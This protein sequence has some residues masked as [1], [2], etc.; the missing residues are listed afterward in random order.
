MAD[1]KDFYDKLG[2]SQNASDEDIRSAF[3]RAA[4]KLHPDV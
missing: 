2:I 3:H 4:R 1:A